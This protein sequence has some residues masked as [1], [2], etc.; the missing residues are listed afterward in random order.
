MGMK[1]MHDTGSLSNWLL[2]N[3]N[4]HTP[5]IGEDVT[6]L[7]WTD[8][9]AWRVTAVDPDGKGATL[10][11]YAPKYVGKAYGDERYEYTDANGQPLLHAD[12]TMHIRYKYKNWHSD[13]GSKIFLSWGHCDEYCDPSF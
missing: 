8:R 10:T 2:N 6:E 5:Q 1:L 3:P 13:G 7:M 9:N 11:R 12:H 4:F